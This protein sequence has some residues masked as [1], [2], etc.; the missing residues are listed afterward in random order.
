MTL[1]EM[2]Y[3]KFNTMSDADFKAWMLNTDLI[4]AENKMIIKAF[5]MGYKECELDNGLIPEA[6]E[7][8]K[9]NNNQ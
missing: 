1:I 2:I 7:N 8:H 5:K 9:P 6:Y 3:D 4:E